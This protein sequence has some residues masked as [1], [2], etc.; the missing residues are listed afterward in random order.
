MTN[1]ALNSSMKNV[2]KLLLALVVVLVGVAAAAIIYLCRI[3]TPGKSNVLKFEGFIELPKTKSLNVLDYL[4]LQNNVLFVTE[5][6]GGNVFKLT[7]DPT[8]QASATNISIL[9]GAGAVHGVA[10]VPSPSLAFVTRS[11]ENT[12]DAFNPDSMQSLAHIPVAEDADAILYD[13]S[14]KL[15]YVAQGDAHSATLIN[16][17]TRSIAGTIPLDG[18]PEFP[19]LDSKTGWLYQN[20]QDT[21]M[22]AAVD[23]AK[24]SVV[25][26]WSLAPCDGPTGM[27]IDPENRRIFSVC[28]RNATIV[29]FAI[30]N[31]KVITSIKI[32]G[33]PD[34]VAYDA[35][36]RRIYTA[37]KSGK[38]NVIQQDGPDIYRT[39]DEI[40]THY[41]A[42]TLT[43]DP[44]T[45]RVFVG[46]ASLL[47]HPRIAV[48]SPLQ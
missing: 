47:A 14:S 45:H 6:S 34:V 20:L 10:L 19:A 32:G 17:Q 36:L 29:V 43:V 15:V 24:K 22:I 1:G 39:L 7:L 23:V 3:G 16:P 18:K 4:T 46:Y 26:K 42:H 48:F 12:V 38:L 28:S 21:N 8:T 2:L 41:G 9:P 5:E 25:G 33:S 37:G 44:T 35:T 31:H 11:E 40:S 30:E 13:P 27:A